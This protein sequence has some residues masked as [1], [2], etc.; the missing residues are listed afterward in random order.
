MSTGTGKER[1][2]A[3]K[4][5]N[6]QAEQQAVARDGKTLVP[7]SRPR[8]EPA[9]YA[10]YAQVRH[11]GRV[12]SR[13][14]AKSFQ[15]L[16]PQMERWSRRRD[17]RKKIQVPIFPGY[18]F[19]RSALDNQEHV[20]ILQTPGVVS[21]VRNKDGPLPV[22]ENQIESLKTLLGSQ[23]VLTSYPYLRTGMYV[24]VV[25]GPL[26]GCEGILVRKRTGKS[27]LVVAIDIIQ[28]AVCVEL[29]EEDVEPISE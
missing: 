15:C 21:L 19:V 13:L 24:R 17:R 3:A 25:N 23:E 8:I 5:L 16:F 10:V 26:C 9:W 18:L 22:P 2:K 7:V 11:E 6:S 4:P 28:Q 14:L 29:N 12:Y 20:R 1:P 27:R